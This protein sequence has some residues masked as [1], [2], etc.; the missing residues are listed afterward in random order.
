MSYQGD[1][2]KS[3]S[4]VSDMKSRLLYKN[5]L[6]FVALVLAILLAAGV[7]F[8]QSSG[9]TYQGRL[10]D[11]GTAANGP[12]DLQFALFNS[13]SAGTQIGATQTIQRVVRKKKGMNYV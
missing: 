8:S 12:Y 7:A 9:F 6:A 11:G 10:T 3:S 4:G 1:R 2:D 5:S 13:L